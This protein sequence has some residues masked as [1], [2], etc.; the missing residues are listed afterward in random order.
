MRAAD[1][2]EQPHH[3]LIVVESHTA[4]GPFFRNQRVEPV[5]LALDAEL[6]DHCGA[7]FYDGADATERDCLLAAVLAD[8][9]LWECYAPLRGHDAQMRFL[10]RVSRRPNG[11]D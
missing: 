6:R 11:G 5:D 7:V 10:S 8:G 2:D 4:F 9:F 1:I 3:A